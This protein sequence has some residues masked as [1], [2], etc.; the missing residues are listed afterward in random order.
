MVLNF[1]T[2]VIKMKFDGLVMK[3]LFIKSHFIMTI[4][5]NSNYVSKIEAIKSISLCVFVLIV[6]FYH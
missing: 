4:C 1:F 2:S 3:A 5:I 6:Y